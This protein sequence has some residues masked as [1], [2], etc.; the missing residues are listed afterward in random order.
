MRELRGIAASPG[1]AFAPAF[2]FYDDYNAS[3]PSYPISSEDV[4]S[5]FGRFT[6]AIEQA[7]SEVSILRDK[8]LKEAGEEQAAIF[9]A[10]LMMIDDPEVGIRVRNGLSVSLLNVESIVFA[11]EGEMIDQLSSSQ[12]PYIQE[13]VSDVHDVVRR[14]LGHLLHRERLSL[15]DVDRDVVVVAKDLLPSDMVGMA[16]SRIK[17]IATEAGGRTSHAAILARAFQIPA[18]LGIGPFM[19]DIK[20]ETPLIVDGDRGIIVIDPDTGALQKERAAQTLRALREK[21][22]ASIRDIPAATRDGTR[23][24]LKANIEVPEEVESVVEHNADGVGLFRSE[25]LFLG[26]HVPGEEAQYRAYRHVVEAMKGK[27]VTIRTLDIGGDKVL[28]E[29]GAQDEKN[30]LLGWRAIRFC[31]SKTEIFRTQLRAI[32]RASV[33]GDV[34]IMFPMI[35]TMEELIKARGILE[36]AQLECR[37]RGYDLPERIKAG[38]MIE[39]PSAALCSDV[40]AR[41]ADFFSIGTNDLTQY[42]MAV[43]RGNEKVAYLHEPYNPAVLRLIKMTI[44]AARLARIEVSLCGEMGG[45][46]EAA[47]LLVGMGLRELSMSAASI[48]AV[49]SKLMSL[50]LG[51]AEGVAEAVM[52]MTSSTQVTSYIASRFKL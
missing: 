29:L 16:R 44:D 15:A 33:F 4:E 11:M 48:P 22:F 3:I 6:V 45:D 38:I 30:P 7:K 40:L 13:R 43:D 24:F 8:A 20:A 36:E 39:V 1:A 49:K 47:V 25:F 28:P 35:S 50:G 27:P 23:I 37:T 10:H 17:G 12:D 9:D 32:L 2:L 42:T 31:L 21:E 18:V 19:A 14:I 46:P 5:E 51:E 41:S 52:K 26:G 34:R